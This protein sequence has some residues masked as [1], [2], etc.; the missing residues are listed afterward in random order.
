MWLWYGVHNSQMTHYIK[1]PRIDWKN[2]SKHGC[3]CGLVAGCAESYV[4]K[5][6]VYKGHVEV[7]F[8]VA[9]TCLGDYG[10][11]RMVRSISKR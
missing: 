6:I 5:V 9:F 2:S 11:F 3:G 4:K 8:N 7:E 1:A 10:D